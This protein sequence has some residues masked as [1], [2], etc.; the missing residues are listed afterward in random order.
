MTEADNTQRGYIYRVVNSLGSSAEQ[1]IRSNS[2]S[3]GE[4]R[5]LYLAVRLLDAPELIILDE[6]TNHMDLP[7]VELLEDA[8]VDCPAALLIVS[9]D[10][11]FAE[12]VCSESWRIS[13]Q[14]AYWELR[15]D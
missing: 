6:P 14:D 12:N 11:T 7:S 9:H 4:M 1:L 5:K 10:S 8:L 13:R 3:P 2:P 15:R